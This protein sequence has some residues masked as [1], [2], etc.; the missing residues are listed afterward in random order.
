MTAL[1]HA[2]LPDEPEGPDRLVDPLVELSGARILD[3]APLASAPARSLARLGAHPVGDGIDVVVSVGQVRAVDLVLLHGPREALREERIGLL[4]ARH[5]LWH[6]H[7][8]DVR[9]GQ[10]YGFRVHGDWNPAAGAFHNPH[11]L[12]LDPYARG[13]DGEVELVPEVFGHRVQDV[14]ATHH[15]VATMDTRDSAPYVA[16][17][18]VLDHEDAETTQARLDRR[19]RTPWAHTVVYEAHVRGLTLQRYDIPQ[20]LRGTYAGLAHPAVIE[21]LVRLGV[22]TLELLPIHASF[23]EHAIAAQGRQNYWGYS[24]L[25]FFAPEPRYATAAS[26]AAGPGAVEAEVKA[27]VDALHDAGI[28]VILDVVYNHT[29]EGGVDGPLL[30]LRGLDNT[31]YY[32]HDGGT[33]ARYADVTGTGNSLDFRRQQVVKLTL[34]SLR[35]WVGEIGVDG[36]RFDLAVTLARRAGEFT[37]DHPFLVAM[38]TDQVVGDV[39]LIAEPWDVGPSGWRTGQFPPPLHEWNDRFRDAARRFWLADARAL[40]HGDQGAPHD[41]RDLATRLSGSADMF[42]HFDRGP[43]ASVN[44][45]TAHDGFTLADL[46]AYDHKHNEANGESNR[47]GSDNN[48]SWNHGVEGRIEAGA[49]GSDLLPIRRRSIRNLLA[50]MIAAA[51]TPMITAGDEFGRTQQGNNN[52]YCQ[53]SEISWVSWDLNTWREELLATSRYL[54]ELRRAN[55]ALRPTRF[56]YGRPRSN[57]PFIDL[58]WFAEDGAPMEGHAWHN[59]YRRVLQMRR[60]GGAAIDPRA[61]IAHEIAGARDFLLVLNGALNEVDVTLAPARGRGWDLV[62]DSVWETPAELRDAAVAGALHPD[63]GEVV[64]VEPLSIRFYLSR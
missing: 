50:T 59:P 3:P 36:F 40:A 39:K 20:Q 2:S 47:D 44:Y 53:D 58:A 30:S 49:P 31:G 12:L 64:P 28:E 4:R 41:L 34:D 45:V 42:H 63:A 24:T 18:V 62:W 55:P 60:A 21:H 6:A 35:H 51:G 15:G 23:T 16:H 25:G 10:R 13:I 56:A 26:R 32:L 61:A 38:A 43:T 9:P 14:R 19:P 46:V 54:L 17:G 48:L 52:A 57:D 7:V 29:A 1:P 33:P 8:P 27:M 37:P 11:K 5:G 22:T